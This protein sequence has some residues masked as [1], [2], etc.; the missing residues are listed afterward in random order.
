M[1]SNG[2]GPATV[3]VGCAL[4]MATASGVQPA[5]AADLVAAAAEGVVLA[6]VDRQKE[7]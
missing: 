1:R 3:D 7:D 5:V 2:M 6:V 4:A